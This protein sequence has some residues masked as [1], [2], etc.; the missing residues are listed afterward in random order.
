M[1]ITATSSASAQMITAMMATQFL[2]SDLELRLELVRVGVFPPAGLPEAEVLEPVAVRGAAVLP[3]AEDV[4][5]AAVLPVAEEVR[6]AAVLPVAE[7]VRGAGA[8][9]AT[10]SAVVGVGMGIT[11]GSLGS[12]VTAF[13]GGML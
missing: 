11:W 13:S 2:S 7:D 3:V 6:G 1:K 10:F 8:L 5:G 4:R 12:L 9:P